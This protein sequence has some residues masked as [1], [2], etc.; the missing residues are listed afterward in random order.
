MI[1]NILDNANCKIKDVNKHLHRWKNW[2]PNTPFAPI[3]DVPLWIEDLSTWFIEDITKTIEENNPGNYKD[4]W[5]SYNLFTWESES[6]KFLKKNIH[7]IYL[8]LACI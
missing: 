4:T 5:Q 8:V 6:I 3:F 1:E 7:R 2:Q